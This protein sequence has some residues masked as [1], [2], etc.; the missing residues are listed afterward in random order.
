VNVAIDIQR[1]DGFVSGYISVRGKG[2]M[3][4]SDL[5]ASLPIPVLTAFANLSGAGLSGML[6]GWRGSLQVQLSE[7]AIQNSWPTQIVGRLDAAE[8]IG[9]ARQPTAIGSYRIEF[10]ST[11]P[12]GGELQGNIAS[13]PDAPLDVVGAVR[14]Q[15]NRQYVID[16][17]VGT[18]A[19]APASIGKALEYLGPADAQGRRPLSLAGSL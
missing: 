11:Q 10:A 15:P 6:G 2:E 12:I 9:P 14:L 18:R 19:N 13:Q 3:R 1:D 16:A 5:R 17:Q 7:L 4:F 8:L